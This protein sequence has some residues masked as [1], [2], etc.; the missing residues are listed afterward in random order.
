VHADHEHPE[1]LLVVGV[2]FKEGAASPLLEEL[3][4]NVPE[5]AG[6]HVDKETDLDVSSVLKRRAGYFHYEGSLTTPPY[7]ETVTWL[8]LDQANDASAEQ[9]EALNRI[10]GNN[11]RHI[12]AQNARLIDHWR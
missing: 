2:L 3:I 7:S 10:E 9:I 11:A 4:A 6:E 1:R 5:H 12:Q 8:V